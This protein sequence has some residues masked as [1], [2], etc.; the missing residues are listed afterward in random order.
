MKDTNA[1]KRFEIAMRGLELLL[2][3]ISVDSF[4]FLS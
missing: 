1:D 4:F 2:A 3:N